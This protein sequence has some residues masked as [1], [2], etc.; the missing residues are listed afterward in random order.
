VTE[1]AEGISWTTPEEV[2]DG[3]ATLATVMVMFC[4]VLM[5]AGAVYIPAAVSV[6]TAGLPDQVTAV[7]E[8]FTI[9]SVNC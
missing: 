9:V 7:F 1:I 6:P 8:V 5:E 3:S 2:F 4:A